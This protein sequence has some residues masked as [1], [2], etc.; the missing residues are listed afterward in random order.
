MTVALSNTESRITRRSHATRLR[1]TR[2]GAM[3]MS[4]ATLTA[5]GGG[6]DGPP[7]VKPATVATV[8]V[9]PGTASVDIGA[10]IQLAATTVDAQNATITGRTITWVSQT[11]ATAT[12]SASGLVTGVATGSVTVTATADG[13]SGTAAIAVLPSLSARCD[14][15]T[16]IALG[17]TTSGSLV[18]TDCRLSDDT[19]ADKYELTLAESTPV[20]LLMN[21]ATVDAYLILQ[22]AVSGQIVS[23]NDDGDGSTDARIEQILPAGRYVIAANTFEAN[24]FGDYKLSVTRATTPCL[25]STPITSPITV[26][27]TLAATACVLGD[28]SYTDR[29][30]LSVRSATVLTATLRSDAFDSFLFIESTTGVSNGRN[31]N[32]GGGVDARLQVSLDPGDYIINANSSKPKETGAYSLILA[33]RIDPCGTS[34][35]L[36]VGQSATDTLATTGCKLVDGSYVKRY[37]VTLAA[38]TAVRIDA[39]ST[40]FDPYLIVQESG[41]TGTKVAEDDDNGVGLNAQVLQLLPAGTFVITVTSA[42]AGETGVFTLSLSGAENAGVAIIVAPS[43]VTLTPGQT[44]QLTATVSGSTNTD[45]AWKS[46]TPAI[47][48]VGATGV[49]RAITA[50]AATITATAAA[51]PSRTATSSVTVNA[52]TDAN[53]DLPLVYLTQSMQTPAGGIPLIADRPT[54]ARVFVRGSRSGLGSAAVRVRFFN[55]ATELGAITGNAVVA[56]ALDE[57]C[58]SADIAVPQALVR[59]GVRLVADVDPNNTIAESNEGDN[60]W[61]LTGNSKPIRVVTVPPI[62]IQL[63]PIR[64]RTTGNVGPSSTTITNLLG[65]MYPL[66]LLNVAVHAEYATDTPPLTDGTSWIGML[67]EMEGLRALENSRAYFFGVLHQVAANGIIGIASIRGFAGVGI[68]GPNGAANETLTHEFGHSFGRFHAPS[69]GCGAPANVDASFPRADGTIG[70]YGYDVSLNAIQPPSRFDIMGYCNNTVWAS[71][72]TYLGIMDYVR[73]GVI[74]ISASTSTMVPSLMITGSYAGGTIDVDPVFTHRAVPTPQRASGRFVAEGLASDGRVLFRHRFDGSEVGDVDPSARIFLLEVPYDASVSGPVASISVR[75]QTGGGIPAVRARAGTYS[76]VPG[77]VSLRIDADPQIAVRAVGANRYD[78][79]WN[80]A[81]YPSVVV[82]NR[83]TGEVL[84]IGRRGAVTIDA[85][86]LADL[87]LLLSDGVGSST[88]ALTIGGAP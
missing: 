32:S 12:V 1:R 49:V 71:E 60:S 78:V 62:N 9:A 14:A 31:D 58:C 55:G 26:N 16:P 74:P 57:S 28:S 61:P 23:E 36:T 67:R 27:G 37:S 40:Q 75:E 81:R 46:S 21:S 5:C 35:A 10:T 52:G 17:Q 33:S 85:S 34:R 66:G 83:R 79:N 80:P 68:G 84:A 88:R 8:R 29:Y 59:D 41:A 48:T 64:H 73:S 2:L 47:A 65:R 24:Q 15:K 51:D 43:T 20:R 44:Q 54:I 77:G 19:Y 42:T 13:I 25:T 3:L 18:G 45:V 50:G 30:A 87:D 82:R 72:Y 7:V 63:V 39:I 53:L 4:F 11:P 70:F 22:D 56:T 76:G 69:P 38:P 86:T 6:G